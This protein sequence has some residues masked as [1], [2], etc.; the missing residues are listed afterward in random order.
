MPMP[1]LRAKA[2]AKSQKLPVREALPVPGASFGRWAAKLAQTNP[3]QRIAMIRGGIDVAMFLQASDYYAMPRAKLAKII[4]LSTA[5]ADRK[6]KSGGKL[7]PAESE[8]LA[9]VA[10]IEAEAEQVFGSSDLAKAWLLSNHLPF[11]EVP[12]SLLDTETGA[13]EVRKVLSA[14]AYGGVA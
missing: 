7:G 5:T 11:G 9:R 13:G 1:I 10:A 3:L 8:R 14:I 2:E 4:G 12:L 6:I